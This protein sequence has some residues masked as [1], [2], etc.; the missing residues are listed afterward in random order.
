MCRLRTW[1]THFAAILALLLSLVAVPAQA[2]PPKAALVVAM[3]HDFQPFTFVNSAGE[4]AGMFVDIWRLWSQKTGRPITFLVSDWQTSLDYVKTGKADVH[5]GLVHSPQRTKWLAALSP[6]YPTEVRYFEL[7]RQTPAKVLSQIAEETVAV[8]KGGVP[9]EYLKNNHPNSRLLGVA[10][11][12]ELPAAVRTG[13]A[14]KFVVVS[15]VGIALLDR[16][17]LT[18][19]FDKNGTVLFKE[20]FSPGVLKANTALAALVGQGM[21]AIT[22]KELAEIEARWIEDP[23]KRQF[24][25]TDHVPLTGKEQRWL[26]THPV[27]RVGMSPVIPPL[28][29]AESGVVKGVE[30]DYLREISERTG[31][32]FEFVILPFSEMDA[33]ARAGELDMFLSFYIP[34]R[35]EY[36]TFTEPFLDFKQV[37][38]ARQEAPV[39]VNL[40]MLNGKRMATLKGVKLHEKVLAPYPDIVP[41]PCDTMEE[42]FQAVADSKADALLSKT[43][44]AAYLLNN[45]PDL[46]IAGVLDLPP[47]PYRYAVRNDLPELVSI[48]N[49]GIAG[50]PQG[51]LD[52]IVGKWFTLHIDYRPQTSEI[53]GWIALTAALCSLVGGGATLLL[54][55]RKLRAEVA[56]RTDE[57]QRETDARKASEEWHRTLISS[58]MDGFWLVDGEGRLLQVN[59]AYCRMSGYDESELLT[60]TIAGLEACE[61]AAEIRGHM[62]RGKRGEGL[63]F[64]TRHRRKDG[65]LFDVEVSFQYRPEAG[66]RFVVFLRD[67][68]ERKLAE[69]KRLRR[70]QQDLLLL[71]E[72]IALS[73][74]NEEPDQAVYDRV[75]DA[76]VKLTGSQYGYVYFYDETTELFT[77]H[78]WS[79]QVTA[80]CSIVDPQSEYSLQKT[81]FW[82]EVVRQRRSIINNDFAA[83]HPLKRGYP[84]GHAPVTRF[85]SVPVLAGERIVA[86]AGVA[87]R[88]EPYEAEDA[89][90]LQDFCQGAWSV[91]GQRREHRRFLD[92]Q[93]HYRLLFETMPTPCAKHEILFDAGGHPR[94]YRFLLV[95]QSFGE[96]LGRSPEEITG[97][98]ARELIPDDPPPLLDRF[99]AVALTGGD[100]EF[101]Y[102]VE[103]TGQTLLIRCYSQGEHAVVALARD[104]TADRKLLENTLRETIEHQERLRFSR[105]LHDSAGQTFQ[106]IRLYLN[107]IEDGKVPAAE[108]PQVAARLDIEVAEAFG[109]LREIA[110]QLRPDFLRDNLLEDAIR[111]RCERL[112][113][114]GLPVVFSCLGDTATLPFEA[115]DHLY[116][117]FQEAVANAAFHAVATRI[118]V[119]LDCRGERKRLVVRDNGRGLGD[120]KGGVGLQSMRERAKMIHAQF[121]LESTTAG[122]SVT[123]EWERP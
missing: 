62:A 105:D 81:G 4:P 121:A 59:Q 13:R 58:A 79:G 86:V 115:S 30:P 89:L 98:T 51:Q 12:D 34:S 25:L 37:V 41:V 15:P 71:S 109:E 87:N 16:L 32:K 118:E 38:V 28:K 2:Q 106:T 82:G 107:L 67:I 78:A 101:E 19:E 75:L 56:L 10:N 95:N 3:S 77:L 35:L 117:I 31:L 43:L 97:R 80:D 52:T 73:G 108:I 122:T 9:E 103:A 72:T 63:C 11:R 114:R 14:K 116:R 47:E 45:H 26:K 92:E 5:S 69:R 42:M 94:D 40:A 27:V 1:R 39:V 113:K 6:F 61:S 29:F 44:F 23:A 33:K 104:V 66:G 54:W 120:R 64:E 91:I 85:M 112:S 24:N 55:N 17:G 65:N 70:Q 7:R 74:M 50:I 48:L 102:S 110:H 49:K 96:L 119:T 18:G 111:I 83:A 88:T 68:S 90:V 57:L 22:H 99:A 76:I 123:V 84:D 100:D 53:L 46:K 21:E 36:M 93:Q 60:M 8:V 20:E